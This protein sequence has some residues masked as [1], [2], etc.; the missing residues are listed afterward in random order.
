[1]V[2]PCDASAGSASD[3]RRSASVLSSFQIW[4][5]SLFLLCAFTVSA[6]P[7]LAIG[8]VSHSGNHPRLLEAKNTWLA[9]ESFLFFSNES[10]TTVG[11]IFVPDDGQLADDPLHNNPGEAR[12]VPALLYLTQAIRAEWYILADDDTF[13][14]FE[15]LR[16]ALS[17]FNSKDQYFLGQPSQIPFGSC[18]ESK[19]WIPLRSMGKTVTQ[20]LP[21]VNWCSAIPG[22]RCPVSALEVGEWC[23]V[24]PNKSMP[25][26]YEVIG[27]FL[28]RVRNALL[29]AGI[30]HESRSC[31][32]DQGCQ[33][34]DLLSQPLSAPRIE[35]T[36]DFPL[37]VWPV[38]GQGMIISAGLID[39]LKGSDWRECLQ[40]LRCGPGDMRLASC[41]ARFANVG[42]ATLDGL[43][44][45]LTRHP[46]TSKEAL[47]LH[48]SVAKASTCAVESVE[49]GNSSVGDGFARRNLQKHHQMN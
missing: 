45:F 16:E 5:G 44:T 42:L 12:F 30:G 26:G 2:M 48:R 46:T 32:R 33:R 38:G 39:S 49:H 24:V 10:D 25:Y 19:C 15:S 29:K 9:K 21:L 35:G 36:S 20:P 7:T 22:G 17:A 40:K 14:F 23:E 31:K 34:S 47:K 37:A 43:G 8:I 27:G 18:E 4:L 11:T 1:M 28:P 6:I 13:I 3:W 41:I